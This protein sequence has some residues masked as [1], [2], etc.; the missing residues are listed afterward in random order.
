MSSAKSN[1]NTDNSFRSLSVM[2]SILI[3]SLISLINNI[4]SN[5]NNGSPC[6]TPSVTSK[7]SEYDKSVNKLPSGDFQE[8]KTLIIIIILTSTVLFIF[9]ICFKKYIP[10]R[11]LQ[12]LR[13]ECLWSIV[14]YRDT[15]LKIIF[16]IVSGMDALFL[17]CLY[18]IHN[19]NVLS[20][21]VSKR[22][23]K[24]ILS[25]G[26]RDDTLLVKLVY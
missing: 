18:H 15:F 14:F 5:G 8:S 21:T 7:Q 4:N 22:F 17:L 1:I 6:L 20:I 13:H 9:L 24:Q 3:Q 19:C 2:L 12:M 26:R 25:T 11:R 16:V 23:F 10:L